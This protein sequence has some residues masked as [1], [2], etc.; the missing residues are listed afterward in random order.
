MISGL[1]SIPLTTW[2]A[3]G[4][5]LT[6]LLSMS[7][8]Y[9]NSR[10]SRQSLE[11]SRATSSLAN[12]N[13]TIYLIDSFR[14]RYDGEKM[15]LYIFST[16]ITN[17]STIQN[18]V[19][20]LELRITYIKENREGVFVFRNSSELSEI[21]PKIINNIV[22]LPAAVPAR[23]ALI[24]TFCFKVQRELLSGADYGPYSLRLTYADG[25]TGEIQTNIIMDVL[26][27]EHLEAKRRTGVP[28]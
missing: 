11:L 23:G 21:A 27:D 9:R 6:A 8:A 12:P 19:S 10:I 13:F 3:I 18:T 7:I 1:A 17:K 15:S 28:I 5:A 16:S 25:S 20:E 4:S 24:A 2:V 22:K 14:Y 26:S